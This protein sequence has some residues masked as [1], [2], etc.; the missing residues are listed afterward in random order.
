M[1][2]LNLIDSIVKNV[3]DKFEDESVQKLDNF[4]FNVNRI[5]TQMPSLDSTLGGGIPLGAITE[6]IGSEGAG[7]TTLGLHIIAECIEREGIAVFFDVEYGLSPEYVNVIVP[8]S[9]KMI[10]SQPDSGEGLVE[11]AFEIMNTKLEKGSDKPC[12][13][14]VDSV[15][16]IR[17]KSEAQGV[18]GEAPMANLARFLSVALRQLN[19]TISRSG[20]AFICLNQMRASIG[21]YMNP[22]KSAGGKALKYYSSIRLSLSAGSKRMGDDGFGSQLVKTKTVKNKTHVPFQECSLELI[23]GQGFNKLKSVVDYLVE[24]GKIT[25]KRNWI[26]IGDDKFNG[27]GSLAKAIEDSEEL[28]ET[29]RGLL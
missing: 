13:M 14:I 23:Y 5:S 15:A 24:I 27:M 17:T 19:P 9:D 25:V 20:T 1:P 4:S 7:K 2:K 26:Y 6:V 3:N 10:I 16:A 11:V 28:A 18:S 8:D 21:A 22:E 29:I 12:V